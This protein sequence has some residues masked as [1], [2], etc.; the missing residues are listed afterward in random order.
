MLEQWDF[1]ILQLQ[2]KLLLFLHFHCYIRHY[3]DVLRPT[4]VCHSSGGNFNAGQSF[5]RSFSRSFEQGP[6]LDRAATELIPLF[7]VDF[8]TTA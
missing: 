2:Q 5:S 1:Y 4:N 7:V 6:Q 3:Y 8:F